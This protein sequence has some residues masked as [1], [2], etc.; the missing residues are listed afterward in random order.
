VG[1]IKA[2][3]QAV[4]NVP[5]QYSVCTLRDNEG[6]FESEA[7]K[8]NP[9]PSDVPSRFRLIVKTERH[10]FGLQLSPDFHCSPAR[11]H[12]YVR[13]AVDQERDLGNRTRRTDDN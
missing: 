12:A 10:A 4:Q 9:Q 11:D 2:E 5:S 3:Y 1:A 8:L 7:Q 13:T 6:A